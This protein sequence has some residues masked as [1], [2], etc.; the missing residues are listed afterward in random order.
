MKSDRFY[1]LLEKPVNITKDDL[2]EVE[3]LVNDY[4]W[5][6]AAQALL[7]KSHLMEG[8][9]R[10]GQHLNKIAI[11]T[12][13]RQNLYQW[14]HFEPKNILHISNDP[15]NDDALFSDNLQHVSTSELRIYEN[16]MLRKQE[17]EKL[18]KDKGLLCFDFNYVPENQVDRGENTQKINVGAVQQYDLQTAIDKSGDELTKDTKDW[19]AQNIKRARDKI[20]KNQI[21]KAHNEDII[22]KFISLSERKIN[23][24]VSDDKASDIQGITQKSTEESPDFFTETMANIY[25]K[26]GLYKKAVATYEKLS[27]KYPEKIIYFA[28]RINEIKEL[29]NNQ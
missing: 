10:F 29:L 11:N 14:L 7:L 2:I 18:L 27:L 9:F 17:L 23:K 21:T 26:Q 19:L 1:E 24:H 4:P 8:S 22:N 5:F 6:Q 25:V 20:G 12:G 16:R 15:L 28:S 13:D 3:Q